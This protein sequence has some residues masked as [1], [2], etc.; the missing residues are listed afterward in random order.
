M[1]AVSF[2]SSRTVEVESCLSRFRIIWLSFEYKAAGGSLVAADSS[3]IPCSGSAKTRETLA[4]AVLFEKDLD[5][6]ADSE[7]APVGRR[8]WFMDGRMVGPRTLHSEEK[9]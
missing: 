7:V 8:P 5:L 2:L 3:G 6:Q 1:D 9:A 4:G